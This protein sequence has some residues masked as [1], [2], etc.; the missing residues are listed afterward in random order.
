M[1]DRGAAASGRGAHSAPLRDYAA[2]R[3]HRRRG[4]GGGRARGS[5][6]R[7]ATLARLRP[8]RRTLVIRLNRLFM[9]DGDAAIDRFARRAARYGRRGFAVESQ[10]RYHPAPEQEGDISAWRR[11][12]RRATRALA[13]TPGVGRA[14]DHQRGRSCRSRRTPPTARSR[15]RSTRSPP[16]SR[17]ATP[18]PAAQGAR[19]RG[20]RVHLRV[21]LPTRTP[22]SALLAV[23]RA[24]G[25]AAVP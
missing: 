21:S 13:A 18:D 23:D 8:P 25:D 5:R 3:R 7:D 15:E 14:L 16:G 20:A 11:F 10:I 9:S 4:A 22:T 6:A 1:P 12:V 19:R 17:P 24:G 2:A